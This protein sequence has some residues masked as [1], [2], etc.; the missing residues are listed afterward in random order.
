MG[1]AS[2][3]E[4][5]GLGKLLVVAPDQVNARR[6]ADLLRSWVPAGQGDTVQLATSD[7]RDAHSTLAR[8][9]LTPEPSMLVTV[10]MAPGR[11]ASFDA[12]RPQRLG[13]GDD[14]PGP[15]DRGRTAPV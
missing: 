12:R 3:T 4:A 9:R 15:A 2:G 13:R 14:R 6:Y 11:R 8:F 7:E 5:R 1:L 10:A